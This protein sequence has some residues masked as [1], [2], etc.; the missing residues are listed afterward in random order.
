MVK[1]GKL[2]GIIIVIL[3]LGLLVGGIAL[4]KNT[5]DDSNNKVKES[6]KEQFRAD[7]K[8]LYEAFANVGSNGCDNYKLFTDKKITL[9]D[10]SADDKGKVI[11]FRVYNDTKKVDNNISF[12]KSQVEKV[13]KELFGEKVSFTHETIGKCPRLVYDSS[14]EIYKPDMDNCKVCDGIRSKGSYG[15]IVDDGK[16]IK[17]T[18]KVIFAKDGNY[19]SDYARTNKVYDGNIALK[20]IDFDKGTSYI[21]AFEKI[22]NN[23]IFSYIEPVKE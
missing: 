3:G 8:L 14:N 22:D 2:I 9:D 21:V 10:M 13:A 20:D 1:K 19:Y 4:S 23:Y 12:T 11:A 6:P 18:A 16:I 7:I 17:V 5:G 15:K